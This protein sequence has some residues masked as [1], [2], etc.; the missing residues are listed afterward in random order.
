MPEAV[1]A[2]QLLEI[3]NRRQLSVVVF[4]NPILLFRDDGEVL[5]LADVCSHTVDPLAGGEVDRYTV[6]C[7]Y[8]GAQF[9][10]RSAK[11]LRM[12]AVCRTSHIKFKSRMAKCL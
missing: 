11:N 5:A 3:S 2:A 12:L 6:P 10:I 1:R 7:P 8:H 4:D 9:D